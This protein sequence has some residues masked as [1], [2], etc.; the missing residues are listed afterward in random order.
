MKPWYISKQK[1]ILKDTDIIEDIENLLCKDLLSETKDF[2][3]SLKEYCIKENGLTIKQY[4]ALKTIE[5]SFSP[6]NILAR[7]HWIQEYSKE[8]KQIAKICAMYYRAT[9]YFNN[10]AK[11][12]I[13][14][15]GEYILT[16]KAYKAMC[17]NEYV[18]RVVHATFSDP[19]YSTG[20]LVKFRK[21]PKKGAL[22]HYSTGEEILDWE[23]YK[24]KIFTIIEANVEYVTSPAKG[25]KKYYILPFGHDKVLLTEERYLK[26]FRGTP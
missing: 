26:K 18:K 13:E 25:G 14:S 12:I 10:L 20:T 3:I 19:Q 9:P 16:V 22:A 7:E 21:S 11:K 23:A 6:E 1:K 15:D 17:E 8:K 4:K 2:L 24:D 5:E